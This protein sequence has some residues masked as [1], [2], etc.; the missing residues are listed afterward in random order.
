MLSAWQALLLGSKF[1]AAVAV[2]IILV[3]P[4]GLDVSLLTRNVPL[5]VVCIVLTVLRLLYFC[6]VVHVGGR[7][8]CLCHSTFIRIYG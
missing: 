3:F 8:I 7:R 4:M 2:S 5:S 6:D 1:D